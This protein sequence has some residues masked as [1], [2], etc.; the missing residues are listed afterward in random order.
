[1]TPE[2]WQQIKLQLHEVLS[3]D[4]QERAGRLSVL[5]EEYPAL[6]EEL[7]ELVS[8]FDSMAPD[9]LAPAPPAWR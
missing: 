7:D 8:S 6:R 3:S 1:M 9:Y 5:A 4:P 2:Q